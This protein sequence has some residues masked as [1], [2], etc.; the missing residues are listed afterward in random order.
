[1]VSEE[2]F[3]KRLTENVI[4]GMLGACKLPKAKR[5]QRGWTENKKRSNRLENPAVKK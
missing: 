2:N 5:P 3:L 4:G 1:M